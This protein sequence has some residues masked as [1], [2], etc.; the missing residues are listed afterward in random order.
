[1]G[2]TYEILSCDLLYLIKLLAHIM[3]SSYTPDA[4]DYLFISP[5]WSKAVVAVVRPTY[6]D[7]RL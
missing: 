7:W 6:E 2:E 5:E 3:V 4:S 1:M